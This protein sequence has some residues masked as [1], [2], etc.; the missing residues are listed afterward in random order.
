MLS[1]LDGFDLFEA[2]PAEV[3]GRSSPATLLQLFL[4]Y[5]YRVATMDRRSFGVL[6]SEGE[7]YL[8]I[9]IATGDDDL[10]EAMHRFAAAADDSVGFKDF[11]SS[12]RRLT[13]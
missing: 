6:G 5:R 11:V 10:T 2:L 1:R 13:L 7:N 12:G 9:S 8:R 4:L 3:K